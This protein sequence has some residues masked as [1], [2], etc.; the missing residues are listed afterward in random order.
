MLIRD[1]DDDDDDCKLFDTS[2]RY[3]PL[4]P[5]K[6]FDILVLLFNTISFS[7]SWYS[8]PGHSKSSLE[9]GRK[10]HAHQVRS[11]SPKHP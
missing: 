2:L 5:I 7:E 4:T 6:S 8:C 3:T 11:F 9:H 10:P 1:D